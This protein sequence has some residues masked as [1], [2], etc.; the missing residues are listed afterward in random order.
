M[1]THGHEDVST[2]AGIPLLE[3]AFGKDMKSIKALHLGNWLTD[4]SQVID[5][6]TFTSGANGLKDG[7]DSIIDRIKKPIDQTL[8]EWSS[9]LFEIEWIDGKKIF[10]PLKVELNSFVQD[11][12]S[13]LYSLIDFFT[14]MHTS[15]RDYRIANWFRDA[16]LLIGYF[17]FVHPE[18]PGWPER[19]NFDCFMSVFGRKDQLFSTNNAADRPGSFTQY[20]P[21]EHLD[22][23][24][25]LGVKGPKLYEPGRQERH[26][27]F[28]VEPSK[29]PGPRSSKL[30]EKIDPDLYSY[31]RDYIQMTAGLLAEVDLEFEQVF[32]KGI[33]R[34]H[35]PIWHLT[36]AKLGHALHQ[37]EDFFAH[38]N[39]FE[40]AAKTMGQEFLTKLIPKKTNLE[41]IDRLSTAYQ[42]RLKRYLTV[43]MEDWHQHPDEEWV[44]SGYFDM[45]DSFISIMHLAQELIG[46]D[47]PDPY[48]QIHE[49]V[50]TVKET[51]EKPKTILQK[52]QKKLQETMDFI[53][54]PKK[55]L[56]DPENEIAKWLEETFGKD[57]KKL[58]RPTV[59]RKIAEKI[60]KETD[61]FRDM[62][63]E[64]L[65]AFLNLIVE[66]TRNI[67]YL[68]WEKNY[69]ETIKTLTEFY[70]G[71][72]AW[73]RKWIPEKIKEKLFDVAKFYGFD[74]FYDFIGAG[75]I[76]C[77]SLMAKDHKDAPF[78]EKQKECATAVHWYIVKTMLRWK[79]KKDAEYIN[80]LE[81][82]E[83]FL[84]NPLPPNEK[85]YII[86][87]PVTIV[88]TVKYKEQLKSDELHYSLEDLYK[89]RSVNPSQFSWK[90]IADINFNTYGMSLEDTRNAINQILKDR[91]WGTKV[92][93]PNYAFKPGLKIFIPQQKAKL[94][95]YSLPDD[96]N[97]WFKAVLDKGWKVFKGY[98][99]DDSGTSQP[100]I[101]HHTPKK[102]SINELKTQIAHAK[103]MR[104]EA[105]EKY[106]PSFRQN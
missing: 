65:E 62:P 83:Y 89:Y 88:H 74:R 80:W 48:A 40:L 69:Y 58:V 10:K 50:Q 87:I 98:E 56:E 99:D 28:R 16:F 41:M 33:P 66:G 49:A 70:Q 61:F 42:K 3:E 2:I 39:W 43:P 34:D 23:P 6:V 53:T 17:K 106:R 94:K 45:Q 92:T 8:D 19:M 52:V 76:G 63:P 14:G 101:E 25:I 77:H 54:N 78:Y 73:V 13:E 35:D 26:F 18:A 20:Y 47:A 67:T 104:M 15:Q 7:I 85:S 60:A 44:V 93:H 79:E 29:H 9:T 32:K 57:A 5:P 72:A 59:S 27:P 75:R 86:T 81:L 103:R 100:P 64:V 37:V 91:N 96:Q 82:L 90:S 55:A 31:L 11:L 102:I 4:V 71:P 46:W 97:P 84:K 24:E 30:R 68:K 36:L 51:V 1:N 22:R 38:S 95:I 12:K 105:R 21:H